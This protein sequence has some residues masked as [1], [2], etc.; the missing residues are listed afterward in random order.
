[1]KLKLKTRIIGGLFCIFSLVII[2]GVFSYINILRVQNMSWELDVLVALDH[3]INEVLEDVHIWR[4]EL[5][6]AIVFD[7]EFTNSLDVAYS[8]YGV[9]RNSPNSIW[10]EDSEIE[11][12]IRLLD[13]SNYNMHT[14]TRTL[15]HAQREG[16]INTAFLTLDLDQ[17][18]LP[19]VMESIYNLQALS[20]RYRELVTLQSDAVWSVQN[21]VNM[22]TLIIII[23]SIAIFAILSYFITLSILNPIKAIANVASDV[24][25]GN[26]NV[27]FMSYEIKD[28]IGNLNQSMLQVSSVI[29]NMTEDISELT[30]GMIVKGD[31]DVTLNESRYEGSYREMVAGL[32]AYTK[33]IAEDILQIL[34]VANSIADG[35]FNIKI[36]DL[37]GKKMILTETL[38]KLL[39]NLQE[40]SE[41][42]S[43]LASAATSGDLSQRANAEKYTGN[44]Q[45][46]L[47]KL[48]IL[49]VNIVDPFAEIKVSLEALSQGNFVK[50]KGTYEGE[51]E[52]LKVMTNTTIENTSNYITEISE[53]LSRMAN[54]N[55]NQ[56]IT[57]EYVG[58]FSKIKNSLTNIIYNLS[59][60]I[61]EIGSAADQVNV[62]SKQISAGAMNLATGASEQA[63]SL[64]EINATIDLVSEG[65]Q[66]NL[67]NIENVDEFAAGS[68]GRAEKS[69]EDMGNLLKA[70]E[71]I[72]DF[73]FKIG[74]IIKVI[75]EIA[76]QTN[77]LALNASVEAARAGEH[78]RG[79]AVVAEEVR[80]LASRSQNAAHETKD[81]IE[82]SIKSVEEGTIMADKT[83][84]SLNQI[85]SDS[86]Q[87]AA[88]IE[89]IAKAT[90]TQNES[91]GQIVMG[92]AQITS[93]VT[94]NSATSEEAASS[95]EE[96]SSQSEVMK[97]LISE[98]IIKS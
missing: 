32:N 62:G 51:F 57:R 68:R 16:L 56:Q 69:N 66:K 12:L 73:S 38:R 48:N 95:S 33:N 97:N 94:S 8:A 28:E 53:V 18:V 77:L 87:I 67:E 7:E 96:L 82:E 35:D 63:S 84:T 22:I 39:N 42:I 26:L 80:A 31:I 91:F 76:F 60:V 9:W 59:N 2:L 29:K 34:Q 61:S 27:N 40:I 20:V 30:T 58:E 98:F 45:E 70:M 93:V 43:R 41:E 72:K 47:I 49:I 52:A 54:K 23:L 11:R 90:A 75:E 21:N 6:A 88:L 83:A 25:K 1:M 15:V 5:V 81:L 46:L 19:I 50:M 36:R 65:S 10:I 71:G 78:G 13:D 79:F 24:A 64:E 37:P 89:N 85:V 86:T 14:Q 17:R 55:F 4:Y 3:S 92:I 74:N 44:W